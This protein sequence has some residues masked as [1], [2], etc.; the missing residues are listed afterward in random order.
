MQS[1]RTVLLLASLLVIASCDKSPSRPTPTPTP[2]PVRSEITVAQVTPGSGAS[3]VF[4][5]C[6]LSGLCTDQMETN[7]D[8]LV[9]GNHP[10]ALVVVSLYRGGLPC[11]DAFLSA[12]LTDG[13]RAS[14]KTSR[15]WIVFDEDGNPLCPLPIETTTLK[16]DVFENFS[17]YPFL[18]RE[19][20]YRYNLAKQ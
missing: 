5:A 11:A 19:L 13:T 7:F 17:P 10:G 14:F 4:G 8:V 12:A 3:L 6:G 2:Q 9:A 15:M 16:F 1:T 20:P 18:T